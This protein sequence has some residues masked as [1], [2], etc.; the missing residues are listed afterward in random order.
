M[1]PITP[2]GKLIGQVYGHY[3]QSLPTK[4][5]DNLIPAHLW[6][7]QLFLLDRMIGDPPKWRILSLIG[8][9]TIT[10]YE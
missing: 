5:V 10:S 7:S 2:L 9:F 3:G 4:A 8:T 6:P 1:G